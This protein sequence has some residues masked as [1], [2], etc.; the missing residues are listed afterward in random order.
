LPTAEGFEAG[1]FTLRCL[2][3]GLAL[4]RHRARLEVAAALGRPPR[5][6]HE[7]PDDFHRAVAHGVQS[8]LEASVLATVQSALAV[9]G[10]RNLCVAGGVFLNCRLNQRLRD[11]GLVSGFYAQPVAKDSGVA[12]GAAWSRACSPG[13]CLSSLAVGTEVTG[14]SVARSLRHFG[15]PFKRLPDPPSAI[16]SLLAEGRVVFFLDGR[17][18]Y[19]PRA[20]GSRSVIA[21]PRSRRM[22]DHV[23][24]AVKSRE[25]WRPFGA[26]ILADAAPRLL[27]GAIGSSAPFMIE[28]FVVRPEWR[29]RLAGVVHPADG[30]TRPHLVDAETQPRYHAVVAEFARRTGVPAI[31]N[32]SL[33]DR[34]KPIADTLRDALGFFFTSAADALVCDDIL[35][36]KSGGS[37]V[38]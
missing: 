37:D 12:L 27:E 17:A 8:I 16:A 20:L 21:D 22:A 28:S 38:R 19:G 9:T 26:S 5:A 24:Q 4:D 1:D 23:N 14:N 7:T 15:V 30:T 35:V 33:N 34:G 25:L 31:L 36:S 2:G 29:D 18:E 11:S 6:P 32:T 10:R 13:V 3:S